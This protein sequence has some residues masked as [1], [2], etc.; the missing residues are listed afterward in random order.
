[1]ADPALLLL[2]EPAAG[3]DIGGRE[4]LVSRLAQLAGDATSPP[5]VLVTHHVEEIPAHFSH[6]L[7]LAPR[8][9]RGGGTVGRGPHLSQPVGMLRAGAARRGGRGPLGVPGR[10]THHAHIIGTDVIEVDTLS[11]QN[12]GVAVWPHP[13]RRARPTEPSTPHNKGSPL[14]EQMN[15]H[16]ASRENGSVA[17]PIMLAIAGDS[18]AGKDNHHQGPRGG[19][20]AGADHLGVC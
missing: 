17:R 3:L 8:G 7:L 9:G 6:V 18:A 4:R 5:M 12:L 19:L 1:M 20:G 10:L 13:R 16:R 2:D 11:G 15:I 14:P